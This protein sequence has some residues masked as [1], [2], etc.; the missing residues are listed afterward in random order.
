MRVF[1]RFI[2]LC[3]IGTLILLFSLVLHPKF[4]SS[5]NRTINKILDQHPAST[6]SVFSAKKIRI[7]EEAEKHLK[8][9]RKSRIL[10]DNKR[11]SFEAK[12]CDKWGVLT[13]ISPPTEALRY[14][15]CFVNIVRTAF[16][17]ES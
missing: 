12:I 10:N 4:S 17:Y 16:S 13:T 9:N 14:Q 8:S 6:G 7:Y 3:T 5:L 11:V 2:V 1:K 15:N